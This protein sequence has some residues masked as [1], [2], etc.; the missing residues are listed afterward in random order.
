[1]IER[2][3]LAKSAVSRNSEIERERERERERGGT[4]SRENW[5][6]VA[7][8][9]FVF[10]RNRKGR[11]GHAARRSA[12]SWNRVRGARVSLCLQPTAAF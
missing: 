12:D 9:A 2:R 6:R 8:A 5:S 3:E 1:M 4:R 10:S 7:R 11:G